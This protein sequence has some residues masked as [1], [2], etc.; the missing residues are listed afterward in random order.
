MKQNIDSEILSLTRKLNFGSG[1]AEIKAKIKKLEDEKQML[2][3]KLDNIA[4]QNKAK[5]E[6]K[7]KQVSSM[8]HLK[9]TPPKD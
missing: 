2:L 8:Y 7:L 9:L 4:R 1:D 3:Q 5:E 6:A